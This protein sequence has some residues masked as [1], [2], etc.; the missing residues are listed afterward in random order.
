METEVGLKSQ[1]A[2]TYH[3]TLELAKGITK[4]R[5]QFFDE[6]ISKEHTRFIKNI[7]RCCRE[8]KDFSSKY[9]KKDETEH[10]SYQELE[11]NSDY[12]AKPHFGYGK[13]SGKLKL[14]NLVHES[15][16]MAKNT[17]TGRGGIRYLTP[18]PPP[19]LRKLRNNKSVYSEPSN[20]EDKP[21]AYISLI[22]GKT[23]EI[24]LP[25]FKECIKG[26]RRIDSDSEMVLTRIDK[27]H[28]KISNFEKRM[29]GLEVFCKY[30]PGVRWN[31][32]KKL[33]MK[34][35]SNQYNRNALIKAYND[36]KPSSTV[37]SKRFSVVGKG[38]IKL[39][40]K[41]TGGA[42]TVIEE[43]A[44]N[45]EVEGSRSE[46][47]QEHCFDGFHQAKQAANCKTLQILSKLQAER[48]SYLRAKAELIL[49]DDEIYRGKIHSFQKFESI[50]KA[51][52][53]ERYSFV[54]KCREQVKVYTRLLDYLK[55]YKG[56]PRVQMIGFAEA[57]RELI[58]GGWTLTREHIEGILA[59]FNEEEMEDLNPMKD[60]VEEYLLE[61]GL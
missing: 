4:N 19:V 43:K 31:N 56:M 24:E 61:M 47:L 8:Y 33:L 50:K 28:E 41:P 27:C 21:L 46:M 51:V 15:Y 12:I 2:N 52:E 29:N 14:G 36:K 17:R 37:S 26:N 10:N 13:D 20:S 3:H 40:E 18:S 6:E 39:P 5:Y 16:K 23:E 30:N 53:K 49:A 59:V 25:S 48:P 35:S 38:R 34:L 60:I 42:M 55:K 44:I 7:S 1:I 45:T 22:N 54:E 11:A 9:N 57:V 32:D 58:E